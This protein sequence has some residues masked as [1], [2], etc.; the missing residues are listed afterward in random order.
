MNAGDSGSSEMKDRCNANKM[1]VELDVISLLRNL[2]DDGEL[3][4]GRMNR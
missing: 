2:D 1:D 3:G 4:I